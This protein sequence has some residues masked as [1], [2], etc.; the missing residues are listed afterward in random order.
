M[1]KTILK[2]DACG[3]QMDEDGSHR[4]KFPYA[5]RLM[6]LGTAAGCSWE[7]I[8]LCSACWGGLQAIAESIQLA[9]KARG[10]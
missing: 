2:C 4:I 3:Q 9:N 7:V 1:R 5:R 8:D 6:W 10:R